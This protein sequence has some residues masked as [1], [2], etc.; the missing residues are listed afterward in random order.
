MA[1]PGL[2]CTD[3]GVVSIVGNDGEPLVVW[4]QAPTFGQWRQVN[5]K[6]QQYATHLQRVNAAAR[7]VLDDAATKKARDAAQKTLDNAG[8]TVDAVAPLL[9]SLCDL[10]PASGPGLP[11]D[12]DDWPAWLVLSALT[13]IEV[14]NFWRRVPKRSGPTDPQ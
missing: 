5:A 7:T 8:D 6:I 14:F 1:D 12:T 13:P 10:V 4:D 3:R 2:H 11:D 9:R